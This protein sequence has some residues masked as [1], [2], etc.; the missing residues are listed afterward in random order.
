MTQQ[1]APL[2]SLQPALRSHAVGPPL[3]AQHGSADGSTSAPLYWSTHA[4]FPPPMAP[5]PATPV[6]P[7]VPV[8]PAIPVLPAIPVVPAVLPA[9]GCSGPEQAAVIKDRP[10]PRTTI[11][12]IA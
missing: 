11:A 5:V 12:I 9:S 10:P 7:A 3:H 4:P 2:L 1:P 6:V 8:V